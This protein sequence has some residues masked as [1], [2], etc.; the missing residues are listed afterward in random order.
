[1]NVFAATIRGADGAVVEAAIVQLVRGRSLARTLEVLYKD[2]GDLRLRV[3]LIIARS[4][5]EEQFHPASEPPQGTHI[6]SVIAEVR[7]DP[8]ATFL[9]AN[10]KPVRL[11]GS[12]RFE[13]VLSP[14]V[15]PLVST[16][17]I[18]VAGI[19]D[20]QVI[21]CIREAEMRHLVGIARAI[22][23]EAPGRAYLAPS[24]SLLRSFVRVGNIQFSRA[25]L[26]AL[27]YWLLPYLA[28][29][30]AIL[31]DTWSI[32]SLALNASRLLALYSGEIQVPV[33]LLSEYLDGSPEREAAA[34]E[35]LDHLVAEA[36]SLGK[37]PKI[38]CIISATQTGS[39]ATRLTGILD[40]YCGSAAEV[41]SVALFK[42]GESSLPGL[43]DLTGTPAFQPLSDA[44]QAVADPV[45]IDPQLYFPLTFHDIE[46]SLRQQD[47]AS[48]KSFLADYGG[49]GIISVHRDHVDDSGRRHH[50]IHLDTVRLVQHPLFRER[51]R[52][53]VHDLE[54]R[55]AIVLSPQHEAGVLL[56][57]EI[58]NTLNDKGHAIRVFAHSNL[59]FGRW[60]LDE[61]IELRQS[62][63]ALNETD[64][65]L[66]VDDI[67]MTGT[68]LAVYETHLRERGFRG[69][70][71]YLVG[72]ARTQGVEA[73]EERR[74]MRTYR[75]PTEKTHFQRNTMDAVEKFF[76]PYWQ[77]SQCPWCLERDLYV[78]RASEGADLPP[79][80]AQRLGMLQQ[81]SAT[82]MRDDLFLVPSGRPSYAIARGSVFA[83]PGA[84]QADVFASVAAGVQA[85]RCS[86]LSGKPP[87]GPRRFPVS[88]VLKGQE[89]LHDTYTDPILRASILRASEPDELVYADPRRENQR[90][91]WV[92]A[93]LTSD[94]ADEWELAPE[95]ILAAALGKC[96]IDMEPGI[97]GAAESRGVRA[98]A[99]VL[100]PMPSAGSALRVEDTRLR[101]RFR[102]FLNYAWSQLCR[103]RA[104]IFRSG[105]Y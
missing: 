49:H 78:R 79:L 67:F 13:L 35:A 45:V 20:E 14:N 68:R 82:G 47:A 105:E 69:R 37:P 61:A 24:G 76:L 99:S 94:R 56:A 57:E 43:L 64:A 74:R 86:P 4:V 48:G 54:P 17:P 32:S 85:L 51:L 62:V 60:S 22:L 3:D 27:F 25:S 90:T 66:I 40:L 96:T 88:T 1:M 80:L 36:A 50:G 16:D 34:G 44:D 52:R 15:N 9:R 63:D 73:W 81:S 93:L 101:G 91:E 19:P 84:S 30:G 42:M 97:L 46:Y 92:S 18:A 77:E 100:L 83:E 7:N 11:L 38:L 26:D 53:L 5:V 55:P 59:I 28:G 2:F 71:H 102:R 8:E 29:C 21:A 23:P 103:V 12:E 104:R 65:I 95:L 87:L 98:M 41:R 58:R 10:D 39:L 33:E 31:T 70:V 75:P 6:A 89:Y 72:V